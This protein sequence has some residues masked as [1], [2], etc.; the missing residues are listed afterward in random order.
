MALDAEQMVDHL[1]SLHLRGMGEHLAAVDVADGIDVGHRSHQI[2]V[3]LDAMAVVVD[4]NCIE[5]DAISIRVR[6]VAM[7]IKSDSTAWFSPLCS[8]NTVLLMMAVAADCRWNVT[9]RF[10]RILRKR[11]AR[12]RPSR[13]DTP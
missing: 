4:A 7:R 6:P 9:P 13:V 12:S 3:G 5:P 2:V 10:S 11:L 8:N 1:S